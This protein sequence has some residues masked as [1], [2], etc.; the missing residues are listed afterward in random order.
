MLAYIVRLDDACT[1]MNAAAWER[2]EALLDRY[3]VR[4]IAGI[5]PDSRDPDFAYGLVDDFWSSIVH[6]WKAKG[7]TIAQH[8]CYHTFL[9]DVK[10]EFEGLGY[11][12]QKRLIVTGNQIMREYG[13]IPRCFYAPAHRFDHITVDA[14]RDSG[15]FEYISDG[16]SLYPFRYRNM[17]FM[18]SVFDKPHKLFP[19][20][21][22]TF[23]LHPNTMLESDFMRLEN[24]LM[25]NHMLFGDMDDIVKAINLNRQRNVF[26]YLLELGIKSLRKVKKVKSWGA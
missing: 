12:E 7:W 16:F 21:V 4:P 13:I 11:E 24:F 6:R 17:L 10:S 22:Y 18:P 25:Q 9:P 1:Q 8:G 2:V 5:I 3:A 19:K 20:G 23:V 15:L 26:D 14:V